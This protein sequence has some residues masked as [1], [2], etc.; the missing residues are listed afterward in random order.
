MATD[1]L[2]DMERAQVDGISGGR[3][4]RGGGPENTVV[5]AGKNPGD[6][7]LSC[8]HGGAVRVRAGR[9]M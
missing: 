3:M 9:I 1:V 6:K 5:V 8:K 4:R 2:L 7:Q